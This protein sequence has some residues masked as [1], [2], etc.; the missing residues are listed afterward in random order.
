MQVWLKPWIWIEGMVCKSK[1]KATPMWICQHFSIK[2]TKG[3][4]KPKS[5]VAGIKFT[6][7]VGKARKQG[8]ETWLRAPG[9]VGRTSCVLH[10][11]STSLF[12]WFSCLYARRFDCEFAG[13]YFFFLQR[14]KTK[15]KMAN[16]STCPQVL[17]LRPLRS[18]RQI[19]NEYLW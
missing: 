11:I 7:W 6:K 19:F 18:V 1:A 9:L 16:K 8:K 2:L 5:W 13:M 10:S 14:L 17:E 3:P 15:R 4:I 12:S